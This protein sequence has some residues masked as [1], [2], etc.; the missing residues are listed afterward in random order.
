VTELDLGR[1]TLRLTTGVIAEYPDYRAGVVVA[2][3][4]VNGPADQRS[5]LPVLEAE[6]RWQSLARPADH[7]HIAAWRAAFSRFGAKPSR[8]PSSAEALM[9]RAIRGQEL[10]RINR[11]VDLYNAVSVNH[12]IPVGGEDLDA[13]EGPVTLMHAAGTEPFDPRDDTNGDAE[14]PRPGE[15]VWA[16]AIGVTCRRWNWRQGRRTQLTPD[17]TAAYFLFDTL[18]P[19]DDAQLSA[20]MDDLCEL[21]T[22]L[23]PGASLVSGV[24]RG[25]AGAST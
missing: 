18:G 2:E 6:R 10:P 8:Y 19:C 20:A 15:V 17:T 1:L 11:L 5:E 24:L 23:C 7:P 22:G 4:L 3:N 21:I 16:D 12:A 9:H 14:H 25:R 13:I